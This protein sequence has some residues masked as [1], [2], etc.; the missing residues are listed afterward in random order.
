M[1]VRLNFPRRKKLKTRSS[2]ATV[3]KDTHKNTFT[4]TGRENSSSIMVVVTSGGEVK[5]LAQRYIINEDWQKLTISAVDLLDSY[6]PATKIIRNTL[7][8]CAGY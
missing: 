3:A 7:L 1:R 2:V 4:D 8:L 5:Q 6:K